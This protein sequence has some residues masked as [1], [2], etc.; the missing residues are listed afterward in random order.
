M[1]NKIYTP[2]YFGANI[3][4]IDGATNSTA[5]VGV[6]SYPIAVAVNPVTNKSKPMPDFAHT[7]AHALWLTLHGETQDREFLRFLEEIGRERIA[8]FTTDDFL[9]IN[10]VH[11]EQPVPD[12]LKSHIESLL[13]QGIIESVGRGKGRRL[14]LSRRFYHHLGKSGVYTR[15]R[16]LDRET[17]KEL[18]LKHIRDSGMQGARFSEFM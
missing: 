4:I 6:G 2:N 3:T 16:C 15:K 9:A 8:D 13:E 1:T 10:Y 14:F 7:D 12:H 17:N 11:C 18:L 5:T